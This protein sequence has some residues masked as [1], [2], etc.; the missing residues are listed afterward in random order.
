MRNREIGDSRTDSLAI[1]QAKLNAR[2]ELLDEQEAERATLS[3]DDASYAMAGVIRDMSLY[4][5][6]KEDMGEIDAALGEIDSHIADLREYPYGFDDIGEIQQ[7]K[8]DSQ[9]AL[10]MSLGTP[11]EA[12]ARAVFNTINRHAPDIVAELVQLSEDSEGIVF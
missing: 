10:N 1:K 12:T 4:S 6:F 8:D 5:V 3:H 2:A 11:T 7:L 9:S